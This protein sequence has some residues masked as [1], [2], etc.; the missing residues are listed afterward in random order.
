MPRPPPPETQINADSVQVAV[1]ATTPWDSYLISTRIWVYPGNA[2]VGPTFFKIPAEEV[3]FF[4]IQTCI[5]SLLYLFLSKPIL[6]PIYLRNE[7]SGPDRKRLQ[8]WRW[9]GTLVGLVLIISGALMVKDRGR[10][11]YMGLI[12]VW[13]IPFV[14]VLWSVACF[15]SEIRMA[16]EDT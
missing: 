10:W 14:L 7:Q 3:F 1:I 2:L 6:H 11:L 8:S 12:I 13:A 9:F 5:T 4:V 16:T 15:P